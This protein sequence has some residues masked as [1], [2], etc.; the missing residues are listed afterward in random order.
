MT[1]RPCDKMQEPLINYPSCYFALKFGDEGAAVLYHAKQQLGSSLQCAWYPIVHLHLTL[2]YIG[3]L[4]RF[5]L[6][7]VSEIITETK[8]FVPEAI[9]CSGKILGMGSRGAVAMLVDQSDAIHQLR[10]N[11]VA[12]LARLD[13]IVEPKAFQPHITVGVVREM[14]EECPAAI[15]FEVRVAGFGL[16]CSAPLANQIA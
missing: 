14:V 7:R 6:S 4:N 10:A 1:N 2:V 11:I 5:S 9:R 16:F 15:D 13:L 3:W 8:Q 12:S